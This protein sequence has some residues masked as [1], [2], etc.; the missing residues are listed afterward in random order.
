MPALFQVPWFN[1]G[2]GLRGCSP[3]P[4]RCLLT[5]FCASLS[6]S[7]GYLV[8]H[9]YSSSWASGA[10]FPQVLRTRSA[11]F[12]QP[13][14]APPMPLLMPDSCGSVQAWLPSFHEGQLGHA[15]D[16]LETPW[17]QVRSTH[18]TTCLRCS[19]ARPPPLSCPTSPFPDLF[20]LGSLPLKATCP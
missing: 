14:Y 6:P 15:P 11:S 8:S 12:L 10:F 2:S 4:F 7:L 5:S 13:H 9:N 18:C 19:L 20:D 1:A 3:H 16:P 17:D